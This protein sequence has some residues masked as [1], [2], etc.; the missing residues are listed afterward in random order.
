[1]NRATTQDGQVL[2]RSTRVVA[3]VCMQPLGFVDDTTTMR[4]SGIAII[5]TPMA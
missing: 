5:G 2:P 3:E 4:R 1:M